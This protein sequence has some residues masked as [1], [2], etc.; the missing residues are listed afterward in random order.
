MTGETQLVVGAG[1][2]GRHL[3]ERLIDRGAD[4]RVVTRHGTAV[5]GAEAVAADASDA[6]ALTAAVDGAHTIYVCTGP[7]TYTTEEWERAWPPVFRAVIAAARET[8]ARVVVQGNLYPYGRS[9]AAMTEHSP[10]QPE[11]GKGRVRRDGWAALKAATDAAEVRA[12]EVRASD[13]FGPHVGGSSHLGR[14]FFQP[15][16]AS[17]TAQVVGDPTVPHSW[18]YVDDMASTLIA[19]ADWHGPWGRVWHVPSGAPHSL[20]EITATL[21]EWFGSH[22]HARG[23]PQWVLQAAGLVRPQ[24]RGIAEESW[25]FRHPFIIDASETER[26]LGVHATP[27]EDALRATAESYLAER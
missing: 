19:A 21:N 25:Q 6:A 7:S 22:G 20:D 8:R 10:E 18:S 12:V 27:W 16:L 13:Y 15:V 26:M 9:D 5:P 2:I 11:T 14:R 24:L 4:V 1:E 23:V 17:H 3:V